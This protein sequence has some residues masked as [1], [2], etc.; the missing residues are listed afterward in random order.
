MKWKVFSTDEMHHFICIPAH[1][2]AVAGQDVVGQDAAGQDAAD[3][4]V[5]DQDVVDQD[6]VG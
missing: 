1:V 6:V 5:A 3:Q 2:A 4:D